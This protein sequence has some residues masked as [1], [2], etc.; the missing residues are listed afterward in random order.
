MMGPGS[1]GFLAN[2]KISLSGK[3]LGYAVDSIHEFFTNR[4]GLCNPGKHFYPSYV[5]G[6]RL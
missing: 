5:L 2:G 3:T 4:T 1:C 6:T